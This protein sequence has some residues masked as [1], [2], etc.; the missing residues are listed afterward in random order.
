MGKLDG[1][2]HVE[3]EWSRLRFFLEFVVIVEFKGLMFLSPVWVMRSGLED[4]LLQRCS[5]NAL[6]NAKI[7]ESTKT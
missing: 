4:P 1:H 3:V 2:A 6:Q 7:T 5:G